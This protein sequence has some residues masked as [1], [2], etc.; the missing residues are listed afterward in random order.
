MPSW[1]ESKSPS[2]E[3]LHPYALINVASRPF[4]ENGAITSGLQRDAAYD[5][6][7]VIGTKHEEPMPYSLRL[8]RVGR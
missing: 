4:H 6:S 8:A 1:L 7:N 2:H 3:I 5:A